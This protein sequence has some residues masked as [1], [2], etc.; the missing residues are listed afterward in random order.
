M[1][2]DYENYEHFKD[3]AND[4]NAAMHDALHDPEAIIFALGTEGAV[5]LIKS[6]AA[7][8]PGFAEKLSGSRFEKLISDG[9][10]FVRKTMG[11]SG[12]V[13]KAGYLGGT[14]RSNQEL[15]KARK[16]AKD[17][18]SRLQLIHE[19]NKIQEKFGG[20]EKMMNSSISESKR[21]EAVGEFFKAVREKDSF[22][23][24]T[25]AKSSNALGAIPEESLGK[26]DKL[27]PRHFARK[28]ITAAV[29]RNALREL[30][31]ATYVNGLDEGILVPFTFDNF[32]DKV[33]LT[34]SETAQELEL[35]GDMAKF[36]A[37]K[38]KICTVVSDTVFY[39]SSSDIG[40]AIERV[41]ATG[42]EAKENLCVFAEVADAES[43]HMSFYLNDLKVVEG[44]NLIAAIHAAAADLGETFSN[45]ASVVMRRED[46]YNC[47]RAIA[48]NG[49][50]WGASPEDILGMP[51]VFSEFATT[52]IVGDFRYAHFN[53]SNI[54]FDLDKDPR[55]GNIHFVLTAWLDHRILI[56]NA[57]RLAKVS[58]ETPGESGTDPENG[59]SGSETG[60]DPETGNT[61]SDSVIDPE[62]DP[63]TGNETGSENNG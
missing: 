59:N 35:Q 53:Y 48:Q 1:F 20:E 49:G 60:T 33:F 34:D 5:N 8:E 62:A 31:H 7:A 36:T 23:A 6:F 9:P 11:L 3:Y 22:K 32:G 4:R 13:S 44:E 61:G 42:L 37:H 40:E 10:Y 30:E 55:S 28:I 26:G 25:V 50:L 2:K 15:E 47:V 41:L 46:Y 27:L 38:V 12:A 54:L 39:L 56:K 14:I 51:V 19:A 29:G 18:K 24:W 63:G 45:N 52:P 58:S 57:F 17:A 16:E 43:S 21:Y